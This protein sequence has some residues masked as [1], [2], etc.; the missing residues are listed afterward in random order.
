MQETSNHANIF[1]H[2][3]TKISS[4]C[5]TCSLESVSTSL[6]WMVVFKMLTEEIRHVVMLAVWWSCFSVH[7]GG[8]LRDL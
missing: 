5:D 8:E 2:L 3:Y 6:H 7:G 1:K 4:Q